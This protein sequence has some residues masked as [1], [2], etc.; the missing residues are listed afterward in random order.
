M[1]RQIFCYSCDT[2]FTV[3]SQ[4]KPPIIHCPFCGSEIS[5][6]ADENVFIEDE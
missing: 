4:G 5:E 1:K 2:E 6:E 3:V